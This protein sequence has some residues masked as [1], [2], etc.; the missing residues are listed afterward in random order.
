MPALSYGLNLQ[1]KPGS[2]SQR[3]APQ[4][5]KTIF[6]D[7]SDAEDG[8]NEN[9]PEVIESIGGLQSSPAARQPSQNTSSKHST[10]KPQQ[11]SHLVGLSASYS[12][13]KHAAEAQEVDSSIYDYDAVY[14][15]LK[16]KPKQASGPS[17]PKYMKDLLNAAEVRKRDQLKAKEKMLA[18]ERE[19]EGDEYAD[20]EKF[21]TA[22]YKAQQ[23]K[24]RE[25]EEEE[26]KR[27]EE[28][29]ER[30]RIGGGGMKGLYK[31]L[32]EREEE[33]HEAAVNAVADGNRDENDTEEV[34]EKSEAAIAKE[35]G[36]VVNDDGQIVDKR[37]LLSAGLNIKTKP[38][39]ATTASSKDI[40]IKPS[41]TM[42]I[43]KGHSGSKA[44]M[45][46]RQSRMI[47]DQLAEAAKRAADDEGVEIEALK[48]A[49]KSRKTG[50]EISNA[51]ERYL[52]RKKEAE[53][54]K[55]SGNAA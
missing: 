35:M 54:A 25:L 10:K 42:A 53:A 4:K 50:G 36:V 15:S 8:A 43:L 38:P 29:A 20:K 48:R 2:L 40:S 17:G 51:K 22:A 7:N 49:A 31:S 32:L 23:E 46:E 30:K 6:D 33:R 1:K 13:S 44:A 39:L 24:V 5:R 16:A 19:A 45:R 11:T 52:Q 34:K 21:V 41:A 55:P 37:Q 18:K 27:E 12:A 9:A 28:E 26:R 47:E 14:D 3:P